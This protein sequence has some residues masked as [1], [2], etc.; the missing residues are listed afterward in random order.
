MVRAFVALGG[1][2]GDVEQTFAAALR[3]LGS[4]SRICVGRVSTLH[5]TQPVGKAS[6]AGFLNAAAELE[7]SLAA[8]ELLDVLQTIE[9]R[10]GRVRGIHWGPRTLDLDL[11]LYGDDVIGHPR[12]TVPHPT[13][14][15]RR[16]V[17]DPLAEIAG[18]IVHPVKAATIDEL[19]QRL[20]VRPLPVAIAGGADDERGHLIERLQATFPDARIEE[21]EAFATRVDEPALLFRLESR[22]AGRYAARSGEE[23]PQ[24]PLSVV[25][26]ADESEAF[27]IVRDAIAAA[28]G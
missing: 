9:H 14:W 15:Y 4:T 19:R 3:E 26:T 27:P 21:W 22:P 23:L 17:L 2:V 18:D 13:L 11:L 28:L 10:H 12:L 24:L 20:L 25:P 8:L 1:N 6:G 16:F 5:R 7:T